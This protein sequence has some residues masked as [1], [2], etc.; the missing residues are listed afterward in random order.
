MPRAKRT[1][2]V[3]FGTMTKTGPRKEQKRGGDVDI[4]PRKPFKPTMRQL[5]LRHKKRK[6][7]QEV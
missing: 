2:K 3:K 7:T 4:S 5:P 6:L 1:K